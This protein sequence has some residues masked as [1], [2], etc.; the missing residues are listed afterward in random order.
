MRSKIF[1]AAL[2]AVLVLGGCVGTTN[3]GV[4]DSTIPEEMQCPLEAR[5]FAILIYNDQPA[6]Q[7][8]IRTP[9]P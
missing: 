3:L 9:T 4:L 2:L 1:F 7:P 5:D 6:G 8:P